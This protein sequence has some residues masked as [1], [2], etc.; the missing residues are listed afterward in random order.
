VSTAYLL[1]SHVLMWAVRTPERLSRKVRRICENPSTLRAVSVA[2]LWELSVKASLGAVAIREVE[3]TLPSWVASLN[4]RVLSVE[5]GHAYAVY[6]LPM[7]HR[8]PFDRM[9]IA[10]AT[11]ED[12]VLVTNDEN[13]HRYDVRW[14]W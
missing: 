9:L 7:L 6:G 5:A 14:T 11:V 8:D 2:S 3:T 13:I 1:D 10:Q 12:L 4:A